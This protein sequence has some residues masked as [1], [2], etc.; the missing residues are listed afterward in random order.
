[1]KNA[2]FC[3]LLFLATTFAAL[4]NPD[5]TVLNLMKKLNVP[6]LSYAIVKDGRVVRKGHYGKASIELDVPLKEQHIFPIFSTTKAITGIAAMKLVED[7]KIRLEDKIGNYLDS[8]PDGWSNISVYQLLTLTSGLPDVVIEQKPGYP[9]NWHAENEKDLI[10]NL[11]KLPAPFAP[12][13]SWSYNQ[14][15]MSLMGMIIK[16]VTGTEYVD[17]VQKTIFDPLGMKSARFGD[18]RKVINNRVSSYGIQ[19]NNTLRTWNTYYY[20]D[21]ALPNA[22]I[23]LGLNDMIRFC[24]GITSNK[25]LKEETQRKVYTVANLKNNKDNFLDKGLGFGMGW[26]VMDINGVKAYGMSGG[27]ASGFLIFPEHKLSVILLTNASGIDV[28]GAIMQIASPYL[29]GKKAKG[30]IK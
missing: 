6:G 22:G 17:Y 5:T 8:L 23:N 27:A 18:V 10:R 15:S 29:S 11:A 13:E 25:I 4:A 16:K 24:N 30:S 12:G 14:T 19:K 3:I 28:E 9:M 2:C 1:M 26:M 20:P 21:F 7:G